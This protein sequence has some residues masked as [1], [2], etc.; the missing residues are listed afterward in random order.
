MEEADGVEAVPPL[1]AIRD[2]RARVTDSRC[3]REGGDDGDVLLPFS[4]VRGADGAERRIV[5]VGDSHVAQ[6]QQPLS[7]IATARGWQLVSLINPGCNLSTRS[8]FRADRSLVE[9]CDQWR[10]GLVDRI[11]ALDPDLV[12]ALGTRIAKGEREELPT[13]VVQAWEQLTARDIPVIGLRDNP[14]HERD[15]P[16]CMAELGDRAP[17]CAV[18]PAEIYDDDVLE[19]DLPP[20]VQVL[21]TRPYFCTSTQCPSVIGNIRVYRD[22]AHVTNMYMRTVRPVLEPDFLALAGW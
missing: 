6:W 2:D 10:S 9:Q 16:D 12:V 19:T 8:E 1:S 20:G 4:P 15:V 7:D 14:R 3:V 13:G 5:L 11:V 22:E 17:A 18:P 21:D